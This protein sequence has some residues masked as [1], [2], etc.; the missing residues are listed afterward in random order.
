MLVK[1]MSDGCAQFVISKLKGDWQ[2]KPIKPK[3]R[4]KDEYYTLGVGCS[5]II[6]KWVSERAGV[7]KDI[8]TF[9]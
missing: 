6:G 2:P 1:H 4:R 8:N 5:Q 9:G 3:S 7:H